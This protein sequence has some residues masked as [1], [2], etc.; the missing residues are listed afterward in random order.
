MALIHPLQKG[1]TSKL[2]CFSNIQLFRWL[3]GGDAGFVAGK[4][5]FSERSEEIGRD[6]LACNDC[7]LSLGG[8]GEGAMT[9][10]LV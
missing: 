2:P 3:G 10:A 7:S 5:V 4:A 1:S 9:G 8:T 6:K